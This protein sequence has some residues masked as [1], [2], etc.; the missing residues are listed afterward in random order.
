[1]IKLPR[2]LYKF[3]KNTPLR[4]GLK[5][6]ENFSLDAL[7]RGVVNPGS[8]PF[9]LERTSLLFGNEDV[10]PIF[11]T[12]RKPLVSD[13]WKIASN[14]QHLAQGVLEP[15]V[16][17]Y[18]INIHIICC[19]LDPE[20]TAPKATFND[21]K[22]FSGEAVDLYIPEFEHNMFIKAGEVMNTIAGNFV[23]F[24]LIFG[25]RSWLHIGIRGPHSPTGGDYDKPR[26]F[27][28][29]FVDEKMY[30]GLYPSRGVN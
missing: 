2:K 3:D 21:S 1:M 20:T 4:I 15:L 17:K 24:G 13:K 30:T 16:E 23:E 25:Q 27:T 10:L 22:H 9:K 29:D 12:G 11:K 14:L 7:T 26:I 6:T 28:K 18:G 19:Y 8:Y 5:A